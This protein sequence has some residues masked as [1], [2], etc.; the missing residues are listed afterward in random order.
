MSHGNGRRRGLERTFYPDGTLESEYWK[1]DGGH[2]GVGR[3]WFP[4]GQPESETQYDHAKVVERRRWSE[5]GIE[6]S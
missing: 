5:D 1:V 3:T 2:H 4:N 6:L